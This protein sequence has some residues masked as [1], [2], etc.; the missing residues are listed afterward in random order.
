MKCVK[1]DFYNTNQAVPVLNGISQIFQKGFSYA[2]VGSSGCG[3]STL[4]HVI[5]GIDASSSGEISYD[6]HAINAM[7]CV[8]KSALLH[9]TLGLVFQDSYLINELSVLENIILKGLIAGKNYATCYKRAYALLQA[10][11]LLDKAHVLPIHLSGGQQQR[12]ALA[13]ALFSQPD[14]LIAD[15]P[16]GSLDEKAS[17]EIINLILSLQ[18][19]Y[20]MGIVISTHNQSIAARMDYQLHLQDGLLT[21]S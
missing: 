13:R 14:F 9:D 6:S 10:M 1:K 17:H 21:S 16:T 2:I 3:K 15:E 5:A 20:N 11:G 18:R 19:S 4:L 12:I 8:Q 7:N